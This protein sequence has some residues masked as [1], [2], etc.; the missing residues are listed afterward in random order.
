MWQHD[1]IYF[2]PSNPTIDTSS[3]S[4]VACERPCSDIYKV[5][6]QKEQVISIC[7]S[8]LT[9]LPEYKRQE[10]HD[11]FYARYPY[12]HLKEQAQRNTM[13]DLN[14][15]EIALLL[16]HVR[17]LIIDQASGYKP[18]YIIIR[19]QLIKHGNMITSNSKTYD[20]KG[21]HGDTINLTTI[22]GDVDLLNY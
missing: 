6:F 4:Y 17:P 19:H 10:D 12:E 15:N 22:V 13:K 20:F 2:V 21:K 8:M 18:T 11:I 1:K 7:D 3:F 9:A 16:D 14:N 5:Y